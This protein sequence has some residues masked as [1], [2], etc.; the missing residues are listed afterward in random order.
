MHWIIPITLTAGISGSLLWIMIKKANETARKE[1]FS[2]V[3]K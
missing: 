3:K 2:K 1:G